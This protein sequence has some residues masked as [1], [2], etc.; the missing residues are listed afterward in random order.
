[1]LFPTILHVSH[2]TRIGRAARPARHAW[3]FSLLPTPNGELLW[4]PLVYV[5]V[6]VPHNE[7]IVRPRPQWA[8]LRRAH[9]LLAD[10]KDAKLIGLTWAQHMVAIKVSYGDNNCHHGVCATIC[11]LWFD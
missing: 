3:V 4:V 9:R 1:M 10:S 11:E 8:S 5:N 2:A 6:Y 7:L